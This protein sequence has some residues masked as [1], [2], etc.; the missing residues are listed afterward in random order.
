MIPSPHLVKYRNR[1]SC[2]TVSVDV[3]PTALP[4]S[5]HERPSVC[6][7]NE[8]IIC[9]AN[10]IQNVPTQAFALTAIDPRGTV[11]AQGRDD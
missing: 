4:C 3:Q 9:A 6:R 2:G 10:S 5:W 7:P 11:G 8:K 1:Y